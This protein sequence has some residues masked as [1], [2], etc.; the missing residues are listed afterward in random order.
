MFIYVRY[1]YFDEIIV[2]NNC[3]YTLLNFDK[4]KMNSYDG[5]FFL[6]NYERGR[7]PVL[8]TFRVF[9][10]SRK[11]FFL[12]QAFILYHNEL[13]T[14]IIIIN[15]INNSSKTVLAIVKFH[16]NE[17]GKYKVHKYN[18]NKKGKNELNFTNL[19]H[20]DLYP[21]IINYQDSGFLF[22]F[23]RFFVKNHY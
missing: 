8:S 21:I 18:N 7:L 23:I 11:M 9:S 16:D 15:N 6:R 12:T 14:I 13:F 1:C 10:Y 4:N 5:G 22:Y 3:Q 19:I 20:S 17:T 2:D